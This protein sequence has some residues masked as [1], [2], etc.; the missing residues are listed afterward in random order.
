[1]TYHRPDGKF[2][3]ICRGLRQ[4]VS[5]NDL[6]DGPGSSGL[7]PLLFSVLNIFGPNANIHAIDEVG[8]VLG[9]EGKDFLSSDSIGGTPLLT[10][11]LPWH[12]VALRDLRARPGPVY[13]TLAS[14]GDAI[15]PNQMYLSHNL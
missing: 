14:T 6:D 10:H 9:P 4:E 8:P 11:P 7:M 12:L 3:R 13:K 5:L 2:L 15:L 1:M